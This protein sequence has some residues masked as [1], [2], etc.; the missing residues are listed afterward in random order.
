MKN[1][2]HT[3]PTRG[4]PPRRAGFS[5][6]ELIGV[7]A[8]VAILASFSLAAVHRQMVEANRDAEQASLRSVAAGLSNVVR[9]NLTVPSSS[10]WVTA[11]A[12]QLN[13]NANDIGTNSLGNTRVMMIDPTFSIGAPASPFASLPYTQTIAG[14]RQ[15]QN[16]N[17]I[18]ISSLAAPLP[19]LVGVTFSNVWNS[20]DSSLP[21]GWPATWTGPAADLRRERVTL[22]GLFY[23]LVMNNLDATNTATWG[24]DGG[25]TPTTLSSNSRK[26]LWVI[27]GTTLDLYDSTGVLFSRDI[28]H[29]D[30]SYIYMN[31]RWVQAIVPTTVPAAAPAD[32][33][34]T[35]VDTFLATQNSTAAGGST[36]GGSTGGT[37]GTGDDDDDDDDDD[38]HGWD[39]EW[40][41]GWGQH[42]HVHHNNGH[43]NNTDG[44]DSSN[45]GNGGGGPNG[46]TDPSGT[47]DDERGC[48]PDAN[49]RAVVENCFNFMRS[50]TSW[51]KTTGCTKT[52]R[53][54]DQY[55]QVCAQRDQVKNS[56]RKC[57]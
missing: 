5:L 19:S 18:L 38:D 29:A 30:A 34:V 21:A 16:L 49:P 3:S 47:V 33:L 2:S 40:Y 56:V 4:T 25:S 32:Q 39:E 51:S 11:V 55:S 28:L 37:G 10:T 13:R 45:P 46:T 6:V 23:R 43:G 8:I 44:V 27:D 31:G 42:H 1:H 35:T 54:T 41:D 9:L 48:H 52:G 53:A 14:S 57:P 7:I 22:S 15:V 36:A 50:Y 26:E 17:V 12:A 24:M 20:P